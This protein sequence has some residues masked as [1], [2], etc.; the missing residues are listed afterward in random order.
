MHP[1]FATLTPF[2]R[3]VFEEL[4]HQ[5]PSV[6]DSLQEHPC[7]DLLTTII[8]IRSLLKKGRLMLNYDQ[9]RQELH[10][11]Q[12]PRQHREDTQRIKADGSFHQ[13][14]CWVPYLYETCFLEG[15]GTLRVLAPR[16]RLEQAFRHWNLRSD[17]TQEPATD[18]QPQGLVP[19]LPTSTAR[20]PQEPEKPPHIAPYSVGL[21][22]TPAFAQ[23]KQANASNQ[24]V[25]EPSNEWEPTPGQ[26][27]S[28]SDDGLPSFLE[29]LHEWLN[30]EKKPE[31]PEHLDHQTRLQY[32][33][34]LAEFLRTFE[35]DEADKPFTD[36]LMLT[37]T[38]APRSTM[39]I[40]MR[41]VEEALKTHQTLRGL[42]FEMQR[43]QVK[44]TY[45]TSTRFG[46]IGNGRIGDI[47]SPLLANFPQLNETQEEPDFTIGQNTSPLLAS[48]G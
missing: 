20:P 46:G 31:D 43:Y 27:L 45:P 14:V 41:C 5:M 39:E 28:Y 13:D 2:Q 19:A 30:R 23:K 26:T 11:L 1:D 36:A 37:A 48:T 17:P 25:A 12:T 29:P 44:L 33:Q 6:A 38:D 21:R 40:M 42:Q 16:K 32:Y 7:E 8:D 18:T 47:I 4:N 9:I 22:R 15:T 35:P 3:Q 24:A 10:V 34:A